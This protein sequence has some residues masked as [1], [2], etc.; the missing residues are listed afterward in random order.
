MIINNYDTMQFIVGKA[1]EEITPE[2]LLEIQGRITKNTLDNPEDERIFRDNNDITVCNDDVVAHI[3][4]E[5][6]K[7]K[8][9]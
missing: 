2:F 6:K 3:P 9:N 5:Y 7:L 1:D 4:P 8:Y